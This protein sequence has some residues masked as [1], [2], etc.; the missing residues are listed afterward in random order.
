MI[1][2]AILTSVPH[3]YLESGQTVA[4]AG[5]FV[6]FAIDDYEF[7]HNVDD[8]RGGNSVSVLFCQSHA[9][10]AWPHFETPW[11]GWREGHVES[12]ARVCGAVQRGPQDANVVAKWKA[13]TPRSCEP[14]V[15]MADEKL[16]VVCPSTYRSRRT[17]S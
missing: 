14:L 5:G 9:S 15:K 13:G 10:N 6:C 7:F 8:L 2:L 17:P 12:E 16:E 3:E 11:F 1:D 4:S